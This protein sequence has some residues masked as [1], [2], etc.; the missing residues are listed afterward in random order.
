MSASS[1]WVVSVQMLRQP[2]PVGQRH[3]ALVRMRVLGP[4]HTGE[5]GLMVLVLPRSAAAVLG[6]KIDGDKAVFQHLSEK[7]YHAL[8]FIG[9][10]Y[11]GTLLF[12]L[13]QDVREAHVI[14]FVLLDQIL[15]EIR[16]H[17]LRPRPLPAPVPTPRL[18]L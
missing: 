8:E 1:G 12:S 14:N 4:S 17:A 16:P 15:D 3:D 18:G 11:E 6:A 13:G 5:D 2:E 9:A 10:K 7:E